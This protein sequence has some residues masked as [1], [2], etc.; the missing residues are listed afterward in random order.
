VEKTN[1]DE[2]LHRVLDLSLVLLVT[3][4][5]LLISIG[6]LDGKSIDEIIISTSNNYLFM[7]MAFAAAA[8]FDGAEA[9]RMVSSS[10]FS[11]RDS[12][13]MVERFLRLQ[14]VG[15]V[16][17]GSIMLLLNPHEKH[18]TTAQLYRSILFYAIGTLIAFN[19][20]V[21]TISASIRRLHR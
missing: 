1:Q 12:S 17:A 10:G 4:W 14:F 13:G 3:S 8:C 7:T 2:I 16:L 11:K 20:V 19:A 18:D 21:L 15:I 6:E 9:S 5:P